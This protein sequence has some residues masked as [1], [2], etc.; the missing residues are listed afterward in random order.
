MTATDL[1]KSFEDDGV[2][3]IIHTD[4]DRDGVLEGVNDGG[5]TRGCRSRV[6]SGHCLRRGGNRRLTS[7]R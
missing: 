5:N 1:A 2:A 4:I 6:D 3:A 7:R